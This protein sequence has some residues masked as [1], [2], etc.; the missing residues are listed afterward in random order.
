LHYNGFAVESHTG[1]FKGATISAST[2]SQVV[3]ATLR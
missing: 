2:E 3:I 1:D